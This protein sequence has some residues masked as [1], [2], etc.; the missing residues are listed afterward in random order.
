MSQGG[1]GSAPTWTPPNLQNFLVNGAFDYWQAGTS[2]T[3]TAT[4]GGT[5][6][7]TYAYQA[8]QWYVNNLLGGGT[9][10]GVITYSRYTGN[11]KAPIY[12]CC[13]GSKIT[14]APTGT[15]IQNGVELWQTL[16]N[17]A[18]QALYN[19]TA[20]FS[21]IIQSL[22]N[23][24]QVG[25]QF[26]YNTSEAKGGTAIGS[27]NLFSL[28]PGAG[29]PATC[30][31]NGQATLEPEMTASGSHCL[32]ESGSISVSSGNAYDLNNGFQIEQAMINLGSVAVPFSRQFNDPAQELSV[33]SVFL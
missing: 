20:S 10:E 1:S 12:G 2:T 31:V 6:T 17:K 24:N 15:G 28:T 14:T 13:P 8:D 27:E 11:N 33:L 18:S 25:I 26:F 3:V 22:G 16:S 30:T 29:H 9:T 5:P 7:N 32:F 23:V 4:G 21:A 19:Q